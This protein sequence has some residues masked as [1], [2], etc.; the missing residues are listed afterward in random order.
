MLTDNDAET[1]RAFSKSRENIV[2][3][4]V[5]GSMATG[6]DRK[7]SDIDLA[8]AMRT[9]VPG[10]ERVAMETTLSNLLHRD[11]DV[12]ILSQASPLLHHQI[13]SRGRMIYEADL[14]E[15]V[16]QE[17]SGRKAYLDCAFLYRK[18][19]DHAHD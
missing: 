1:I 5:F 6:K 14:K 7:T 3:A 9:P 15:R 8:F 19:K 13:L 16:R 17:V 18:L 2:A 11:V 12:V 10:Q 4:Y